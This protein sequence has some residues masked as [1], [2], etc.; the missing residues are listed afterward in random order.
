[1]LLLSFYFFDEFQGWV[2]APPRPSPEISH[3][4]TSLEVTSGLY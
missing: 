3:G 2:A 1:M 4:K